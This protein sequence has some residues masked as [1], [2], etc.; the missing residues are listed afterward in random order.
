[1]AF[2]LKPKATTAE[3]NEF[4]NQVRIPNFCIHL[5]LVEFND[6]KDWQRKITILCNK[7][8]AKGFPKDAAQT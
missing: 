4:L 7:L 6:V 8:I 2:K 5:R 1:M 3:I